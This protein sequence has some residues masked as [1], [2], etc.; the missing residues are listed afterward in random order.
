V[1][2]RHTHVVRLDP[3]A[4]PDNPG[5]SIE[6]GRCVA[7]GEL[8]GADRQPI[9]V[10]DTFAQ[11]AKLAAEQRHRRETLEEGAY[12]P[13]PEGESVKAEPARTRPP[14]R[15]KVRGFE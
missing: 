1:I 12:I 15:P 8:V 3:V 2:C 14:R 5:Q 11:V 4:D 7:C 10:V 9:T 13:E 6:A